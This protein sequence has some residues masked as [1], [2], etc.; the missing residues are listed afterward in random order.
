MDIINNEA[1][2]TSLLDAVARDALGAATCGVSV[3]G[4]R[5]RIH[6]VNDNPP[7]QQRA[8]DVFNNFDTLQLSLSAENFIE[9]DPDPVIACRDRL[10]A[11]D[12]ALAYLVV[13][14]DEV[15]LRD[16]GDV[17]DGQFSLAL[18]GLS[19][20]SYLVFVYRISGNYASGSVRFNVDKA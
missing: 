2:Q 8:S 1:W 18:T 16:R 15:L 6:L 13:L 3:G 4:G 11:A 10:I 9:G 14:D 19:A 12:S 5:S 7:E 17:V 20:G